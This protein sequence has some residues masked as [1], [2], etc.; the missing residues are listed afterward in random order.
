LQLPP[1]PAA[2]PSLSPDTHRP[3]LA[4]LLLKVGPTAHVEDVEVLEE[5]AKDM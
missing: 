4:R 3:L 1:P 5:S 2:R